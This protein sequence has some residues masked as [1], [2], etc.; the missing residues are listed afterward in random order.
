ML[1]CDIDVKVSCGF[2]HIILGVR[3]TGPVTVK[4]GYIQITAIKLACSKIL[5]E[6]HEEPGQHTILTGKYTIANQ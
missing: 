6:T 2:I 5:T 3:Q 1:L 4:K